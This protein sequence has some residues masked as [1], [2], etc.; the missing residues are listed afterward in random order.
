MLIPL[1]PTILELYAVFKTQ[2]RLHH[3]PPLGRSLLCFLCCVA[4]LYLRQEAEIDL[5]F[6]G[7]LKLLSSVYQAGVLCYN[8]ILGWFI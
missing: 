2:V 8:I 1:V 5:V 3:R 7:L 4:M 6:T